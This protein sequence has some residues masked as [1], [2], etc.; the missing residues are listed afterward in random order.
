[1][2]WFPNR[3]GRYRRSICLL[4]GGALSE[5][6]RSQVENH[7][8]ACPDCKKY[9]EEMSKMAVP[10]ANWEQNFRHLEPDQIVRMRWA[11]A[12]EAAAAPAPVRRPAPITAIFE[13][14]QDMIG[15][16]RRIWGGLA[17]I[18]VVILAVNFSMRADAQTRAMKSSP[19]SP[20][21]IMAFQQQERLLVELIGPRETRNAEPS[22]LFLPQPRSQRRMEHL[23]A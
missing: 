20:E 5:P 14:G 4:A 6:E 10:L 21:M 15:P 7:L 18:W 23:T 9:H 3:C 19:S 8:A 2:N 13:W 22:K 1:M 11:K 16:C 12:I 17:V